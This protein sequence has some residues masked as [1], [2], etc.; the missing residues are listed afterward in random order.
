MTNVKL[1]YTLLI[2][3][4]EQ[5]TRTN[6][7]TYLKKHYKAVYEA[8]DGEEGYR[9]Y[10]EKKPHILI[11][12]INLP[13]MSGLVLLKKIREFDQTTKAIVFTAHS[14]LDMLLEA[15]TLKLTKYLIKPVNRVALKEAL[16]LAHNELKN[17]TTISNNIVHLKNNFSYSFSK[18]ELTSNEEVII[19]TKNETKLLSMILSKPKHV[20]EYSEIIDEIWD[21]DK[22]VK[23]DSLKTLIKIIRRKLPEDTI[24]NVFG[25]GYRS[26]I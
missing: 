19:L 18:Q 22:Y 3:E 21:E 7:V 20:F 23:I 2:V 17:F 26:E 10:K 12:D 1:P 6:Y 4:D 13:K 9:V 11:V 8:A 25:V 5:V 16:L 14:Q 24:Q 15:S